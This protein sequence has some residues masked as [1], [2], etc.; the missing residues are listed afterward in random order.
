MV[1]PNNEKRR[2]Y[3]VNSTNCGSFVE[4]KRI[5]N[6]LNLVQLNVVLDACGIWNTVDFM[7]G[8]S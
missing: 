4:H 5:W 1:M 2:I 7:N 8:V 3:A 6:S